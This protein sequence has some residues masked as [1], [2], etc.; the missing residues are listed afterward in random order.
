M[1]DNIQLFERLNRNTKIRLACGTG[2]FLMEEFVDRYINVAMA[3]PQY[4]FLVP[5][6]VGYPPLLLNSRVYSCNLIRNDLPLRWRGRYNEDTDL[7]LRLLKAGWVTVLFNAFL[8]KKMQTQTTAGGCN[9]DFYSNEGTAP[10]SRMQVAL[11]PDVSRLTYRFGRIHHF[12]DY[13]PFKEN[14]LVR[15]PG[16]AIPAG[17]NEHGLVLVQ[18]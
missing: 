1:D 6:K 4:D 14:R 12:V 3:G 7:S 11:H 17:T 9:G 16:V 5:R 15:R 18:R 13:R 8:Q 10:K 2:F